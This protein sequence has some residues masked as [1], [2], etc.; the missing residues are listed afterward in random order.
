MQLC[1]DQFNAMLVDD[2][3][4]D[5]DNVAAAEGTGNASDNVKFTYCKQI[6]S[7]IRLLLFF[8]KHCFSYTFTLLQEKFV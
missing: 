8:W 1:E 6:Y 3:I 2:T 4:N 5:S 7:L